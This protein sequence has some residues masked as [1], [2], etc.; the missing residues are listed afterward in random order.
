MMGDD[1]RKSLE[2]LQELNNFNKEKQ[3]YAS[4]KLPHF[5]L[6]EGR[7]LQRDRL[8]R[9]EVPMKVRTRYTR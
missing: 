8:F 1:T 4:K 6:K 5:S 3:T 7:E 2:K 9:H